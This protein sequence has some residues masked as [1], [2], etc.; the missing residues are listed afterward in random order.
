MGNGSI[1]KILV[2]GA[3]APAALDVMR[4]LSRKGYEVYAGDCLRFPLGRFS[5]S[6][7]AYLQF[8]SPRHEFERFQE[9]LVTFVEKHNIDLI[10]PTCEEV[11]YISA[12]KPVLEKHCRVFCEGLELLAQLHNKYVFQRLAKENGLGAIDTYVV[13]TKDATLP[14]LDDDKSYVAK[15][16]FSRFGDKAILDLQPEYIEQHLSAS[17]YP[18]VIQ[19]YVQGTEFCSY[20]ICRSGNV[21]AEACYQPYFRAKQGSSVYFKAVVKPTIF[22]QV[23]GFVRQLNYTGQ[24]AFDFIEQADGQVF[25]LECNPRCTSGMHLFTTIDWDAAFSEKVISEATPPSNRSTMISLAMLM[26]G[27]SAPNTHGFKEFVRAYVDATDVIHSPR[28]RAPS[29][30]QIISVF[31]IFWRSFTR[32]QSLKDA[33]T[34]D[35][36]WDGQ[37]IG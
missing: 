9:Q 36:E 23:R 28:D 3:R 2:T 34:E 26:F 4:S 33:S 35:I 16:A 6:L 1:K 37:Q 24:I 12:C 15:P 31:E 10:F 13:E 30:L 22:E 25:V 29:F 17:L 32:R 5:S 27:M 7:S 21:V 14:T 18:W 20:A 19:E 8:A 11:F